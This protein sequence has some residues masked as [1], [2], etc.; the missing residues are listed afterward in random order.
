MFIFYE[1]NILIKDLDKSGYTGLTVHVFI[2]NLI[3]NFKIYY[4]F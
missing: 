4:D 2:S 3:T 1:I